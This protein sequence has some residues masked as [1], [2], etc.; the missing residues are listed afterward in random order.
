MKKR[1]FM[2]LGV[3]IMILPFLGFPNTWRKILFILTGVI[4][5]ALAVSKSSKQKTKTPLH[6]NTHQL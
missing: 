4:L 2:I 5:I 3:W 1:F 6:E